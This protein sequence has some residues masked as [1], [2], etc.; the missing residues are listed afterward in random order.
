MEER[1]ARL[2]LEFCVQC[3]A[4]ASTSVLECSCQ[5]HGDYS[6]IDYMAAP[7]FCTWSA[8]HIDVLIISCISGP[9]RAGALLYSTIRHP[10]SISSRVRFATGDEKT[11]RPSINSEHNRFRANDLMLLVLMLSWSQI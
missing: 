9:L 3:Q 2:V 6:L 4:Q 7:S 5:Q 1:L 10:S 11:Q 8:W